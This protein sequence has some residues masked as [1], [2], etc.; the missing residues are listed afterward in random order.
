MQI[1]LGRSGMRDI[2]LVVLHAYRASSTAPR[3][4]LPYILPALALSSLLFLPHCL[5]VIATARA[6]LDVWF[7]AGCATRMFNHNILVAARL[8]RSRHR[9]TA[10]RRAGHSRGSRT[11]VD[12]RAPY[13]GA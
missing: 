13:A 8:P 3:A 11:R 6:A 7:L 9:T 5:E 12:E 1:S 10:P 2:A 4:R